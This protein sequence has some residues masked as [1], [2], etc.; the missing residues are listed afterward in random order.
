MRTIVLEGLSRRG[1]RWVKKEAKV[2][3]PGVSS[4]W[5]MG[6]GVLSVDEHA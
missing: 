3:D 1:L 5:E 6:G 4:I 2:R